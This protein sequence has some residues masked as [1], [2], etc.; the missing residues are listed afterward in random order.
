[1]EKEN[2]KY[3]V[4]F[5]VF[6]LILI[7]FYLANKLLGHNDLVVFVRWYLLLLGSTLIGYPITSRLFKNFDDRGYIFSKILGFLIPGIIVYFLCNMHILKFSDLT[8]II[9]FIL[10][11]L[12]SIICCGYQYFKN[13][14]KGRKVSYDRFSK[15][16]KIEALFLLSMILI[17][18]VKAFNPA[19]ADIEKF[20]DYGFVK[21]LSISDYLPSNDMWL[22]GY[23]INYYYFGHYITAFISKAS[24]VSVDYG[25][26]LMLVSLFV[27][28]FFAS[29]SIGYTLLSKVFDSKKGKM[30]GWKGIAALGGIIAGLSNTVAGNGHF[31]IYR[32]IIPFI[33]RVLNRSSDYIYYYPDSTRYIGEN[34]PTDDK[35]I[36][37][38]PSY[39]FVVGDLHAHLSD[40]IYVV[41]TIGLLLAY[42]FQYTKDKVKKHFELSDAF[43]G[44]VIVFGFLIGIMKMTNYWDFPIYMVVA[45][46]TFILVGMRRYEKAKDV[47]LS[48]AMQLLVILTIA[49]F[50]SLPSTLAFTMI[51]T[52]IKFVPSCTPFYQL[53]VL[54]GIPLA[55]VII[56]FAFNIIEHINDS[57]KSKKKN[58]KDAKWY[59]KTWIAIYNYFCKLSTTDLFIIIL[60]ISAIGL[61]IAP[62]IIYVVDIYDQAPRA[63]TMFKFTYNSYIMFSFCFGYMILK[64]FIKKKRVCEV[65]SCI[66]MVIFISTCLYLYE[67]VRDTFSNIF[68]ISEYQGIDATKF[69]NSYKI[70]NYLEYATYGDDIN[71]DVTMADAEAMINYLR[72]N[73][74]PNDVIIEYYGDDFSF[75]NHVSAFTG[76]PS[77]L[78]WTAHEWLWRS[79]KSSIDFP[80]IL[81]ERIDDINYFYT[82]DD[83]EYKKYLIQKYN[84]KYIIVGYMERMHISSSDLV[85]PNEETLLALGDVVF[86]TNINELEYPSYIIKVK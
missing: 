81:Q 49:I 44:Y 16:L 39:S 75:D 22:S 17:T 66:F 21:S 86:E 69:L 40:I 29:F 59:K 65:I 33:N 77:V 47:I 53:M 38:F 63:N 58:N 72:A 45:L 82:S 73:S 61:I 70:G 3:I 78:G 41:F 79:E 31:L 68:D 36:H 4:D 18:Y 27:I 64:L 34:P 2:K 62:E 5:L 30:K 83:L 51:S 67:P 32:Y 12:G 1:M 56:Y 60:S 74:N 13:D 14:E 28:A 57:K 48:V 46:I 11:M 84:I 35:T 50:I 52:K 55:L 43:N 19:A 7:I 20:M 10:C 85:I 8:C 24:Q 9:I 25:F 80:D 26:N 23:T 15:L 42:I 71:Y 37:E 6:D 54:W 76:L